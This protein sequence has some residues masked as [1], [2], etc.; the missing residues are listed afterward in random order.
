M[1][2]CKGPRLSKITLKNNK[3]GEL[4][5]PHWKSYYEATLIKNVWYWCED[6]HIN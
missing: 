5:L 3:V 1:G 4:T 6:R 2:K